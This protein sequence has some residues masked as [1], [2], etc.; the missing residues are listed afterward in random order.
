MVI[1]SFFGEFASAPL[2]QTMIDDSL[3]T[4]QAKSW[5]R[6]ML[7]EDLPQWSLSFEQVIGRSRIEAAASIVD[8]D[9]PAPLRSNNRL[10]K[11]FGAIPTMKEKFV[12]KQSEL[13]DL[14]ALSQ[15]QLLSGNANV[16]ALI[17]K[18]Y[19]HV[20]MAAVAG[21]RRVDILLIQAISTLTMDVSVT[22]NPDGAALGTID[23]L[24]QAYQKQGVPVVWT[25]PAA[26]PIDDIENYIDYIATYMGRGFGTIMM[27]KP[28][29]LAFKRNAQ[30]IDRLKSFYNIGK[31]NG[32]YAATIQNVNEMLTETLLPTIQVLNVVSGVE[33]DGDITPFRFFNNNNL[34]FLPAG[35][36]GTLKQAI[37][38]ERSNPIEGKQ[39]ANFGPTL[40]SKWAED[41]PYREFTSMEMNACPAVEVDSIFLLKTDTVQAAFTGSP[42]GS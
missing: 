37:P 33:K 38:M 3:E 9:S 32:T 39:Y 29:W 41:D 24:P 27:S 30:V 23:L 6:T 19:D 13:R 25:D 11:Y 35:K 14:L 31:S 4:L 28:Q 20:S 42:S 10:E 36:I 12:M 18:L 17:K 15:S 5:W 40:V 16:Q 2:L 21:D 26:K 22:N 1:P 8:I 7:D 34:A